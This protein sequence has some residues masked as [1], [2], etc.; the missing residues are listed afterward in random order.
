MSDELSI[1]TDWRPE[2]PSLATEHWAPTTLPTPNDITTAG[3]ELLVLDDRARRIFATL[4]W[5]GIVAIT[6]TVEGYDAA[7]RVVH[8]GP[9]EFLPPDE[10]WSL[11]KLSQ[12]AVIAITYI[13]GTTP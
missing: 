7:M 9:A 5:A 10:D 12:S 13:E 1:P 3:A 6:E 8:A 2:P 11:E 4:R